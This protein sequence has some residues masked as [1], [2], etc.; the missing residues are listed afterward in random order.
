MGTKKKA[1]IAWV[2]LAVMAAVFPLSYASADLVDEPVY[3]YYEDAE[4][5]YLLLI[6]A[7]VVIVATGTSIL[8]VL[9]WKKNKAGKGPDAKK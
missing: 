2:M 6:I 1:V 3:T 9:L 4:G 7:L 8:I 5:G